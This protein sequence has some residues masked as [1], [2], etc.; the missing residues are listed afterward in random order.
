MEEG[1]EDKSQKKREAVAK[2]RNTDKGFI[3]T[4]V[5]DMLNIDRRKGLVPQDS[6]TIE[7]VLDKLKKQNYKC[8]YSNIKM[9]LRANTLY[10]MSIDRLDNTLGH[11]FNNCVLCIKPLNDMKKEMNYYEFIEYIRRIFDPKYKDGNYKKYVDL[12]EKEKKGI[13]DC[14][15]KM[16][17]PG[18]REKR[19]SMIY[20]HKFEDFDMIRNKFQDR[21][22]ITGVFGSWLNNQWNGISIDRIDSS[23]SYKPDNIQPLLMH[24]NYLKNEELTNVEISYI[25]NELKDNLYKHV[26]LDND[27]IINL[28]FQPIL[29]E[30]KFSI[31]KQPSLV[32]IDSSMEISC[33]VHKFVTN[34]INI[35]NGSI[36]CRDCEIYGKRVLTKDIIME[37]F[38]KYKCASSIIR[39]AGSILDMDCGYHKF[40]STI[41]K[42]NYGLG[43]NICKN[44]NIHIN[45]CMES[46]ICDIEKLSKK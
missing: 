39:G 6:I 3:G 24:I 21:C 34:I 10:K 18:T 32:S 11:S 36:K 4:I 9:E 40:Q 38:P 22:V 23:G 25:L 42:L 28:N 46:M 15:S 45:S 41:Y 30:L 14:L 17:K 1:K 31:S 26:Q 16:R 20:D 27:R 8:F 12:S 35:M 19:Q 13:T 2:H 43:C 33:G 44:I 37:L 7:W 29:N 5:K